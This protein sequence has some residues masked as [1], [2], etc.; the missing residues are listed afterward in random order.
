[1]ILPDRNGEFYNPNDEDQELD[2]IEFTLQATTLFKSA[3]DY[4]M[5]TSM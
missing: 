4:S 2:P 3:E 5:K 1:M